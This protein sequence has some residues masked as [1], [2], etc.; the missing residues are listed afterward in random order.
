MSDNLV[1][2]DTGYRREKKLKL[3]S[4]KLLRVQ[5]NIHKVTSRKKIP[6]HKEADGQES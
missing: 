1:M 2:L 6:A 3:M 4:I 5:E